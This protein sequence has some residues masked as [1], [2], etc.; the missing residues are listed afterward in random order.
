[1]MAERVRQVKMMISAMMV[2][3]DEIPRHAR[4]MVRAMI[5]MMAEMARH[6]T[7]VQATI[8]DVTTVTVKDVTP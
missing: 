6:A 3:M 2:M 4:I 7:M 8:M 1:M 5:V